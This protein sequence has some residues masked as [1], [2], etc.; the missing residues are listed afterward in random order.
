MQDMMR[1]FSIL[2]ALL[3]L[4]T[5]ARAADPEPIAPRPLASALHAMRADRWDV[6]AKLAARDGPVAVDMI[7]WF[8]LREGEGT[9]GEVL[10]FL[11]RNDDWPGVAYLRKQS[12][13]VMSTADNDA[14]L[15]FYDG[16]LPQT[17]LGAL[18]YAR[19]LEASERLERA[20]IVI[21]LAWLSLDLTTKEHDAILA[22][23]GD[24]LKVHHE[25]RLDMALWRGLK[26]HK[27]M[28]PLASEKKRK[29]AEIRLKLKNGKSG[30]SDYIEGLPKATREDPGVAYEAFNYYIRRNVPDA[31]IKTILRQSRMNG[32]LSEPDRWAGWRRVLVRQHMGEGNAQLAYD[33]ASVHQ[34]T[35]GAS[36]ADLEWLSGYLA[37]TYLDEPELALDHFQR[38]RAAVKSPISMGRAGYWLGRAQDA[39][40]DNEAAKIA[41]A[42]GARHQTSFYGLL[43]AEKVE[44]THDPDLAGKEVFPNWEDADFVNSSLFKAMAL[45]RAAGD[46]NLAERFVVQMA[47]TLSRVELGQLG[48]ALEEMHEPHLQVMMGKAAAK[49]GMVLPGPYYALHPMKEMEFPVPTEMALAIARRESEFDT[50]VVSGA[51]AQG[52]MQ[53][54]PGTAADVARELG[55]A[56]DPAQVLRNWR[57]NARLGSAYLAGLSDRFDSNVILMSAG[58]N[59]GPGRPIRW[60]KDRGDPRDTSVDVIDWI[61]HIPFRETRNYVMRVAESLPVYRARLGKTPHP[62]PFSE[63]LKG[64]TVPSN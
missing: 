35:N 61:E 46:L 2:I 47:E 7:E 59:A 11:A 30:L 45:A 18:S 56:H 1:R 64:A 19:A 25:D 28:L 50:R 24:E 43:A 44:Q 37:L 23:Y 3:C 54:L 32:G 52:L 34:M 15:R 27:Q 57:Y 14:I 41:Y 31:A 16:Y 10:A 20:E 17:G 63:E 40:G 48:D 9:P 49:R 8:R 36:Y 62:V 29:L 4:G 51:K 55:I 39:L 42:Q 6:A 26:D 38:F 53:I 21:T 58:Y 22:V 33:L 13:F 5:I 60:M 12:E